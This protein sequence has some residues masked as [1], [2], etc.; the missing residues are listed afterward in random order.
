MVLCDRALTDVASIAFPSLFT[1]G[2]KGARDFFPVEG[3]YTI[4]VPSQAK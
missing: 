4:F 3:K 2:R 1:P